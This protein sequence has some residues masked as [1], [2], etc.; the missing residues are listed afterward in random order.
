MVQVLQTHNS[1]LIEIDSKTV[2]AGSWI[3]VVDPTTQDRDWLLSNAAI[4]EEYLTEAL[5]LDEQ[6]RVEKEDDALIILLRIPHFRGIDSDQPFTTI[7]M[8]IV[9]TEW[10]FYTVC[11][12]E[13]IIIQ[14]FI[15]ER[16]KGFSTAKKNTFLLQIMFKTA[17]KFLMHLRM[18]GKI[19]E[20]L[21]DELEN[22]LQN[23][24]LMELLKYEKAL[25]YYTTALKSNDAMMSRLRRMRLFNTF[26]EDDDLLEEVLIENAQA[27]EMTNITQQIISQM[28]NAYSAII[29]NNVNY[30]IKF[31]TI[32][33]ICISIPTLV[34]SFYGMNIHLPGENSANV[35]YYVIGVSLVF[36]AATVLYFRKKKWF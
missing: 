28:T 31:L 32:V 34:A 33:T 36:I 27:I 35:I 17:S 12:E 29:N 23:R 26:E 3:N 22:S 7:P 21:E 19:V 20:K 16:I 14:E 9:V 8:L 11:K 5:D 2:S 24:E 6:S 25:I 4:V 10:N 18:I 15:K 1:K 30:V 13:N